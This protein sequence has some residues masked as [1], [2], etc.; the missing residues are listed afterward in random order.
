MAFY[1]AECIRHLVGHNVDFVI[2]GNVASII[3]GAP[4]TTNDIDIMVDPTDENLANLATALSSEQT[5]MQTWGSSEIVPHPVV[6]A[7]E[8]KLVDPI[9]FVT[10]FGVVDVM[11]ELPAVGF[12]GDVKRG[13]REY[14]LDAAPIWVGNLD[15]I[16]KSKE[17][18]DRVKDLAA[19]PVLYETKRF[20]DEQSDDY[21]V[22]LSRLDNSSDA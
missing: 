17:A 14:R 15:D 5:Q 11:P 7:S 10:Q 6:K 19:L 20:L 1:P 16:I 22:D 8:L 4:L 13:A 3:Q 18:A 21:E 2:V 9:R 12:F